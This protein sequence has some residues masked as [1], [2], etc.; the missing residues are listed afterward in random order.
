VEQVENRMSETEYQHNALKLE[1]NN[2]NNSKKHA[3]GSSTIYI[4]Q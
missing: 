4:A 3:I 1:V 2:K